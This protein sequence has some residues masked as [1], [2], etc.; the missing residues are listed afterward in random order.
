MPHTLN[1]GTESA[2]NKAIGGV[3]VIHYFDFQSR[4]RGQ[5][6]RLLLIVR[7][8]RSSCEKLC[9]WLIGCRCG[10]PGYSLFLWR[11][12]RTQAQ[13]SCCGAE[14]NWKYS[15][16]W[17]AWW[18]NPYTKLCHS[19]PLG[20]TIGCVWRQNRGWEVL[21]GCDLWH[22]DWLFVTPFHLRSTNW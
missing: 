6:V 9:L 4:G 20:Q 7:I 2:A 15:C 18:E 11:M 3:P 13:R 8:P 10:I 19:P 12:A 16:D 21:G 14:S 1:Y 22:C 17:N 5:A